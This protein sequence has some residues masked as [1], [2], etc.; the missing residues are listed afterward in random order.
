MK[1]CLKSNFKLN[2][3]K[4][5]FRKSKCIYRTESID[6]LAKNMVGNMPLYLNM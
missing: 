4:K 6:I 5:E 2:K 3:S 1:A